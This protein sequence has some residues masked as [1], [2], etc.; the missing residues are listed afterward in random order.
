MPALGR[1]TPSG[2][3]A[4]RNLPHPETLETRLAIIRLMDDIF[5]LEEKLLRRCRSDWRVSAYSQ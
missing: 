5:E 4:G 3:I 2:S 1:E